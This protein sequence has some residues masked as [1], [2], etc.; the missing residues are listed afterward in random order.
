MALSHGPAVS[1][2]PGAGAPLHDVALDLLGCGQEDVPAAPQPLGWV[3]L[4][5]FMVQE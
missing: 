1:H 3:C 4:G 2:C 5:G